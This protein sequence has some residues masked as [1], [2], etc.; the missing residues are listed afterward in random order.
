MTCYLRA[1]VYSKKSGSDLVTNNMR[2]SK[3]H[4][5]EDDLMYSTFG[6]FHEDNCARQGRKADLLI[7]E[8]KKRL[9]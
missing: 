1:I 4:L 8:F 9:Y 7:T 5:M 2:A 3:V 6:E